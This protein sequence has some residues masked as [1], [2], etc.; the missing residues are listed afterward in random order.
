M[1][2]KNGDE[3]ALCTALSGTDLFA[4]LLVDIVEDGYEKIYD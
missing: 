1:C 2:I 3:K 4:S